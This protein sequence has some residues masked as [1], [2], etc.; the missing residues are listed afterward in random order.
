MLLRHL[1]VPV[2]GW[3]AFG[4]ETPPPAPPIA[5]PPIASPATF[6]PTDPLPA[7]EPPPPTPSASTPT[8][9]E[10]RCGWVDNPTPA[11]WWLI[12]REATWEIGI[13]GGHQAD[14]DMPDFGTAWVETNGHYGYGCACVNMRADNVTHQVLV[15]RD[16][17]A[18]PLARCRADQALPPRRREM[19]PRLSRER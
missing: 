15:I 10:R 6:L 3:L 2:L 14:G 17:K 9:F 4:C 12:D 18:L 7:P 19:R 16:A 1:G 5:P 8:A 13:Q 11:N